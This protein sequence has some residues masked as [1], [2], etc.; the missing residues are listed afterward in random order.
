MRTSGAD[1]WHYP[2]AAPVGAWG[3]EAG[4]PEEAEQ[5]CRVSQ[6]RDGRPQREVGLSSA[7]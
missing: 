7:G 4:A 3:G 6:S 2:A 5:T 1:S